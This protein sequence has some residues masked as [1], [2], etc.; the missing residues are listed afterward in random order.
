M[1]FYEIIYLARTLKF[2]HGLLHFA[3][4]ALAMEKVKTVGILFGKQHQTNR[5]QQDLFSYFTGRPN[6]LLVLFSKF[7]TTK[8][9]LK[10][11]F[12][13]RVFRQAFPAVAQK[14]LLSFAT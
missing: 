7:A 5:R 9:Q 10:Q 4:D 13:T 11:P 8:L 1:H 14:I 12:P 6:Y 2:S 3:I